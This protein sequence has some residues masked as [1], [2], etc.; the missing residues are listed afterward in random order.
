MTSSWLRKIARYVSS[1]CRI[2]V[3]CPNAFIHAFA[4]SVYWNGFG[5][6][7]ARSGARCAK[8]LLGPIFCIHWMPQ[9]MM[10]FNM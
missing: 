6:S 7:K 1:L 10:L 8:C 5:H 2:D 3:S 9:S 4:F